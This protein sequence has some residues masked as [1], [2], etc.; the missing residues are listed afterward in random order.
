M[1]PITSVLRGVLRGL[2]A[3]SNNLMLAVFLWGNAGFPRNATS[4][5]LLPNQN[6]YYLNSI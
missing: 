3:L 5:Y 4:R 6:D 2:L 1:K